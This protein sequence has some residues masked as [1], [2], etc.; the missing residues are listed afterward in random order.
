[1]VKK[2]NTIYHRRNIKLALICATIVFVPLFIESMVYDILPEDT[3]ISFIPF[4]IAILCVGVASLFTIRFR[5]M[6]EAQEKR[7]NVQF[8]DN[9]VI[10]LENTLYLSKEWLISA[11]SCA[12]YKAHIQSIHSALRYSR[13]GS[14]NEIIIKTSDSRKYR[15]W[16]LSSSNVKKIK[17]WVKH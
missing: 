14:S 12:I 13:A 4:V 6:I 11:G 15:I 5:R 3:F 17:D 9:D 16:C 8:Q 7:Y 1:M 10:H 2:Y